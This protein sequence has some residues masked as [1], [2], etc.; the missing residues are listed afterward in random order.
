MRYCPTIG[1]V[2][3][4]SVPSLAADRLKTKTLK[5]KVAGER[6]KAMV[7]FPDAPRNKP[8]PLVIAFHGHGMKMEGFA[9]TISL[10]KYWPEAVAVYPQGVPTP[11]KVDPKGRH[12]GWQSEVGTHRNRDVKFVAAILKTVRKKHAIDNN[13]VYAIDFSN[14]GGFTYVLWCARP[15]V[16]AAC[17]PISC[18]LHPPRKRTLR[19]GPVFHIAGKKDRTCPLK[20]QL[21]TMARV[22]KINGCK[23][24]PVNWGSGCKLY[25]PKTKSGAPFISYIHSGGHGP[26]PRIVKTIVQFFQENPRQGSKVA[27][28]D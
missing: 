11:S 16:F 26:P 14:G 3:L 8:A 23:A 24:T 6:R 2:L 15:G 10:Q 20:D 27:A 1:L 9:R 13:R 19:P 12:A 5:L 17:A 25:P 4:L 28:A 22:R 21:E 7:V 18:R